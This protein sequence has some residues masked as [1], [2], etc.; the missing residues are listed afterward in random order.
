MTVD[1]A[2]RAGLGE[3]VRRS[4]ARTPDAPAVHFGERAWTY[5][6]LLEASEA[7]AGAL[8]RLGVSPGDRVAVLGRNSDTYLITWLATQLAGAIHVPVNFMLNAREVAYIVEHSG[9]ALALADEALFDRL[10]GS[11]RTATLKDFEAAVGPR[12]VQ[13]AGDRLDRRRPDRL[14][15]RNRVR[16]QGRDAHP[17]GPA[18]PVRL[19][20]R[21]RRVR[22]HRR[23]AARA[24]ALP[25]RADALLHH[26]RA[27]PGR[28]EHHPAR[29][30]AGRGVR[31]GADLRRHLLLRAADGLDR[32]A[33]G[34]PLR[35]DHAGDAGQG[36]LR[37]LDHAGP[38]G[39]RPERAPA[40]PAA[41]ELLRPDRARAARDLPRPGRAADQA[42]LG[43]QAGAQ[44]DHARGR[45][46][47]A[48]R[49]RGARSARSCTARRR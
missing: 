9:A 49:G 42:G 39:P 30:G 41:V 44:R 40:R 35:R 4:A 8:T 33:A 38:D 17:R 12:G 27:L 43:G 25:L 18:R 1:V 14:H 22:R 21:R 36:L 29:A 15:E 28:A 6:A 23:D 20:H 37:R 48:R 26:A 2:R 10:P 7:A 3:L 47:H 13:R 31:C 24:A 16:A 19:L 32:P 11:T 45:R 46:G 34:R 5:Q